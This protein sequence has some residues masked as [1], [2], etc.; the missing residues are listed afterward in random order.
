M[1]IKVNV[2]CSNADKYEVET[3]P[4]ATVAEFK[5][6]LAEV[7]H[8]A[9]EDQRLIYKGR[10]LKDDLALDFYG[11]EEGQTVHLVKSGKAR[12]AATPPVSSSSTGELIVSDVVV[13]GGGGGV[14]HGNV[15]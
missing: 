6:S 10:V 11:V 9:A 5:A 13:I 1:T 8:V 7:S 3:A 12:T 2:K 14:V 15:M 4:D